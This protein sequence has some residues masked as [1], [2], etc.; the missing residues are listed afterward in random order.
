MESGKEER[1]GRL[2]ETGRGKEKSNRS[3]DTET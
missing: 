1:K 2:R 3:I